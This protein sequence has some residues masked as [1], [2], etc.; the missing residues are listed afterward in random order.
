MVKDFKCLYAL[1]QEMVHEVQRDPPPALPCKVHHL[2]L[3]LIWQQDGATNV[4]IG[5]SLATPI[6]RRSYELLG[7]QWATFR[8]NTL[9]D[10]MISAEM[11][12]LIFANGFE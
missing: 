2:N 10:P 6:S 3:R 11:I 8:E 12:D 1:V 7:G 4:A 9:S 5:E